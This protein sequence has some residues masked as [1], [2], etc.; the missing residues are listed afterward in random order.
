MK[1]NERGKR[2]RRRKSRSFCYEQ[3]WQRRDDYVD[4]VNREWDPSIGEGDLLSLAASL[5]GLKSSLRTWDKDVFGSVRKE[6]TTLREQ[7][8]QE[9]NATLYQGPT[10]RER[11]LMGE[12]AET[13]ARE[14]EMERQRS[15]TEWLKSGDRNTGFFQAK[16]KARARANRILSLKKPDGSCATEQEEIE[17]VAS[18]FYKGCSRPKESLIRGWSV[19]TCR[20][21]LQW[22]WQMA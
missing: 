9:R 4:F 22:R 20:G 7:I 5:E 3:M 15:R 8:E 18:E 17:R 13:L 16:A 10:E 12:L 14:E 2:G 1:R 11:A 21:K 19:N 6:L